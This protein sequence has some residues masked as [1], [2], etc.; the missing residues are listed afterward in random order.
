MADCKRRYRTR[1]Q[2]AAD[3]LEI[4]KDGCRK[5]KIMY[6]GNLSFDVL[7]RYLDMLATCGLIELGNPQNSYVATDKGKR[8]LEEYHE[9]QK[10]SEMVETKKRVLETTLSP[11]VYEETTTRAV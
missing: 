10:H 3:I 1:I 5:T 11:V 2:I 7:R 4:A 8:F 6:L 9:L